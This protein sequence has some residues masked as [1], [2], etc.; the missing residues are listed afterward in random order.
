VP[1]NGVDLWRQF[2]QHVQKMGL[3]ILYSVVYRENST[4]FDT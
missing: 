1:E 2:V 4:V 3:R